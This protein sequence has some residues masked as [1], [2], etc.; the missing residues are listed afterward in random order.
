MK[1]IW[2]LKNLIPGKGI[3]E[4]ISRDYEN[5]VEQLKSL[6]SKES[7]PDIIIKLLYLRDI[8]DLIKVK[9]FFYPTYDKLHNPF[10]MK[11][12][13]I[14]TERL[15]NVIENKEKILILGDYDVDGT[16]GTSMFYL[17]LKE[18]GLESVIYIPDRIIEGYGISKTAIDK[19]KSENIKLIVSIDCGITAN[20]QAE[21]AK[22]T[23]IELIICDHHHP[24]ET[25]PDALAVLDPMRED[26]SYPFK[27]LC[28][29]GVAFK[30]IQ[31]ICIKKGNTDLPKKFL[32]F[33][34]IAT[35]SDIVPITDENRILVN[36]GFKSLNTDPRASF[37]KLIETLELNNVNTTNT[38][39]LIA[40]RINAV[41]RL[42][43]AKRA[44]EL[45]TNDNIEELDELVN[46]LDE[47]N[48]KRR[49]FDKSITDEAYE[50][51]E[52]INHKE[53]NNFSI[54]LH[55]PNWH[56]G[57]IGIVAARLAE[58]YNL[59]SIVLTT[60]NN[61]AKGSARSIYGFNIYNALRRCEDLLIQFG[62][63]SHAAGLEI[64]LDKID[65]FRKRFNEIAEQDFGSKEPV[66]II[67]IDA[68]L[69]LDEINIQ[70]AKILEFFEPFGPG[71][72]Q[73]VFMTKNLQIIG[74]TR[75]FEKAKTHSFTLYDRESKKMQDAVFFFSEQYKDKIVKGNFCDVCYT[76]SID[77]WTGKQSIKLK[78]KDINFYN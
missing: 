24:P 40:P 65:E 72:L 69:K 23:G 63:H 30:L 13:N 55:N 9:K 59:P 52:K 16:C 78:I 27:Y 4:D 37:K 21:Y 17:F 6:K 32:D 35:A 33:V 58:K 56:P 25:I 77:S 19:A 43:D 3:S 39:Y 41:G 75:F 44:V 60:I 64:S 12:C 71:N 51:F 14:A 49:E 29:T 54:V 42:G 45:L 68:E 1:K 20:E 8:K 53:N 22:S 73:P 62:G 31:A 50:L 74:E 38:I 28:G 46:T 18:Y 34:A 70:L 11:D 10:L 47:E 26:C 36:E 76:I 15:L 48:T 61:V 67:E 57:I 66:P 2:K 5:F 7:I